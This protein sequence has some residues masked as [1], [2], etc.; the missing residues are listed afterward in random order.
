M[1]QVFIHIA[2]L[3]AHRNIQVEIN[4]HLQLKKKFILSCFLQAA[5]KTIRCQ[6]SPHHSVH[7]HSALLYLFNKTVDM[8]RI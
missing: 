5:R 1:I 3:Q 6:F 2:F 4:K 8:I 7:F